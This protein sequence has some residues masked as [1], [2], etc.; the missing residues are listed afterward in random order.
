MQRALE[1]ANIGTWHWDIKEDKVT[2]NNVMF[3][4]FNLSLTKA[5]VLKLDDVLEHIHPD[6][7]TKVESNIYECVKNGI[8]YDTAF[9]IKASGN[10]SLVHLKAFGT[11]HKD[12]SGNV[13]SM[14]GLCLDNTQEFN[15][16]RRYFLEQ[17]TFKIVYNPAKEINES[18]TDLLKFISL[19]LHAQLSCVWLYDE[20]EPKRLSPIAF[21]S[22]LEIDLTA[23]KEASLNLFL[24]NQ[25][26]IEGII[27]QVCIEENVIYTD[28]IY[29]RKECLRQKELSSYGI[30]ALVAFPLKHE[31]KILGIIEMFSQQSA[32]SFP[33][34]ELKNM[35]LVLGSQIGSLIMTKRENEER[36]TLEWIVQSTLEPI[37]MIDDT[38]LIKKWNQGAEELYKYYEREIIGQNYLTI[39]PKEDHEKEKR[40]IT[41]L[42]KNKPITNIRRMHVNH[43]N[44]KIDVLVTYTPVNIHDSKFFYLIF[45]RDITNERRITAECAS[46]RTK[47]ENYINT[48]KEWFWEVDLH[49]K[50]QFCSNFASTIFGYVA[51]DMINTDFALY[52]SP[53]SRDAAV[54][55]YENAIKKREGWS[56]VVFCWLDRY[57]REHYLESHSYPIFDENSKLTGFRGTDRDVTERIRQENLQ[58]TF[59]SITNHELRAPLAT[60]ESAS[61]LLLTN[62]DEMEKAK[63]NELLEIITHSC[64]KMKKLV[65]DVL[66]IQRINANKLPFHVENILVEEI[67]H[68]VILQNKLR[69]ENEGFIFT[70][71]NMCKG[72]QVS[73]DITRVSEI[74]TNFIVNA[75]EHSPKGS[76]ISIYTAEENGTVI[77]NVADEGEGISEDL[78]EDLFA[79][80]TQKKKQFTKT[81]KSNS[82]LGLYI[83]KELAEQMK[84]SVGYTSRE[85]KGV[86][87]YLKLPRA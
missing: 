62:K 61:Q 65:D 17:S 35:L 49:R 85:E 54:A 23:F 87:F 1:G 15:A 21:W 50:L 83:C 20:D 75:I 58:K 73:A 2:W 71:K 10:R 46:I 63:E 68:E 48:T 38:G 57:G 67:I 9:C 31:N 84:G 25:G 66:Y 59:Y 34:D 22:D 19:Q 44:Q 8:S 47:L 30:K 36:K 26:C 69:V 51:E 39:I 80:Y 52:L 55:V 53:E 4:L 33:E 72:Y 41:S 74:L 56:A 18:L 13:I 42:K 11:A 78:D 45:V 12:D 27:E 43:L 24:E 60:I 70:S 76:T 79:P 40:F 14:S 16:R 6:D 37:I 81:K 82:G 64:T 3:H 77:F 28:N 5:N 32:F 7:R 29:T 86:I